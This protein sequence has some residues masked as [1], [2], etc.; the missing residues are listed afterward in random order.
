MLIAGAR[1]FA[2][3]VLEVI[4]QADGQ[5]LLAF[6]DDVS[7]DLPPLLYGRFPV[8]RTLADAEQWL[9]QDP[10]FALG[11]GHPPTRRLLANKLRQVGGLL[12]STLSPR[13]TIGAFGTTVGVGCN[14]MS[15]AVLTAD[16]TLG[17]GVL[18]NLN[19]TI[20]HDVRIGDYCE[21]SP[22]VHLSG[23]VVLGPNC[24][25]GTG[26]VVLPGVQV[27]A[28]S[29]IGAGSVVTKDVAADSLAVGIPAKVI[30]TLPLLAP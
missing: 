8:W 1:G 16:V 28:N 10:R 30:K 25:L 23:H 12:T 29:V 15:G 6:Y 18:I 13:A 19:C 2:K 24:V 4:Y 17:E 20:G 26:A 9:A 7:P 3:E 21:L 27:G 5:A 14:V 22:G 11:T